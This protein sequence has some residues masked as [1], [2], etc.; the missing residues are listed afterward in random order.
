[1]TARSVRWGQAHWGAPSSQ[2]L[3]PGSLGR[4]RRAVA[5]RGSASLDH[6]VDPRSSPGSEIFQDPFAAKHSQPGSAHFRRAGQHARAPQRAKGRRGIGTPPAPSPHRPGRSRTTPRCP[7]TCLVSCAETAQC[8]RMPT[9]TRF[10]GWWGTAC[11]GGLSDYET[12]GHR[13]ESCLARRSLP[14]I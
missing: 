12:E 10:S 4:A 13:F 11:R 2:G 1:M 8:M 14:C 9:N 5:R 7:K 6:C 3:T